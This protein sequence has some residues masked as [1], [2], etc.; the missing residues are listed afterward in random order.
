MKWFA[1]FCWLAAWSVWLWLGVGLFRELPRDLGPVVCQLPLATNEQFWGFIG[2]G[3]RIATGEKLGEHEPIIV[4]I[5]DAG[6]GKTLHRFDGPIQLS[7]ASNWSM[8]WF[9]A[10]GSLLSKKR[11]PIS[12]RPDSNSP[13][14]IDLET[15][16]WRD[17]PVDVDMKHA[18]HGMKPWTAF[19]GRLKAEEPTS[20]LVYDVKTGDLIFSWSDQTR[21]GAKFEVCNKPLFVGESLILIPVRKAGVSAV[22]AEERHELWSIDENRRLNEFR[23]IKIGR[24][25]VA[26]LSGRIAWV[27]DTDPFGGVDVFDVHEGRIVFSYPPNRQLADF[28]WKDYWPLLSRD[29]RTCYRTN[30]DKLFDVDTGR[31]L[32]SK[33]DE[34]E[35][36]SIHKRVLVARVDPVLDV[37]GVCEGITLPLIGR[38]LMTYSVRRL[39]TGD[40]LYRHWVRSLNERVVANQDGTLAYDTETNTVHGWPPQVNWPLLPFCQTILALPLVLLWALLQWRRRRAARRQPAVAPLNGEP[41]APATGAAPADSLNER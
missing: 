30:L 19:Y 24:D 40:F 35:W 41:G 9:L 1:R 23:D 28:Q 22:D 31:V 33:S 27:V 17:L 32:W 39:S 14:V 10:H 12:D 6:T 37:F 4:R 7:D 21:E 26:S 29:G 38:E 16:T 20:V 25:P 11:P 2:D 8:V 15:G 5:W 13:S 36:G 18:Y 34:V 3:Q